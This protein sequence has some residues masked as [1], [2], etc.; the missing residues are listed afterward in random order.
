M[1]APLLRFAL[2]NAALLAVTLVAVFQ[3]WVAPTGEVPA[4]IARKYLPFALVVSALGTAL[5]GRFLAPERRQAFLARHFAVYAVVP[6]LLFVQ[7]RATEPRQAAL[8]AIYLFAFVCWTAHA[9]EGLWHVVAGL[10]DRTAAWLLAAVV[11]VPF[12]ALLPYHRAVMPTASDEPIY[13]V[14]MQSVLSDL[15]LDLRD[16]FASQG[17][18]DFYPDVLYDH[19]AIEVGD[20]EYPIRDL[21]LPIF[22][23]LPFAVAGR[24]GVLA[25][26]CLVGAALAAQLYQACRDLG[27][28]PRP[29]FLATAGASLAHPILTYTTQVYPELLAALVFVVAARLLREGRRTTVVRLALASLAVGLLPWLSTRAWLVAV[30]VGLVIAYAALR[31]AL[32]IPRSTLA[33]RI[34]AGAGPFAALVLLLSYLDYLM[35]GLFMPSAGYYLIR[36]QQQVLAFTPHVGALGLLFDRVFGLVPRMPLVLIAGIGVVPLLRRT[37]SA[38]LAALALGWLAYFLY[39]ANIAYWWADGSPPSRYLLAGMP[40]VV[41]LLAAGI[42]RIGELGRWRPALTAVTWCLAAYSFFIAFVYAVLPN[43][44]YDL[45]VEIRRTGSDGQLFPFVG[46]VLRPDPAR[47]F[48]SLVHARAEDL[49][50]AGIWLAILLAFIALGMKTPGPAT[51]RP[52]SHAETARS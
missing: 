37:P 47:L 38:L 11:L 25:A 1:T 17:Y 33:L 26:M 46:R 44:G 41:V 16:E 52:P 48:P 22:G 8:G 32:G 7:S 31:P 10:R 39:I 49:A 45:A 18:R 19:H 6:I 14:I 40:F 4:V 34:A 15:D 13:L 50:L 3:P 9:L 24:T 28:A 20:A 29:A 42:E 5:V 35:F 23:A 21:G 36:D 2:A 27:I 12:L 43:I 51:R 30:G